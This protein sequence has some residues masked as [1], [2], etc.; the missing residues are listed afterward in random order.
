LLFVRAWYEMAVSTSLTVT[1]A[2]ATTLP[3]GS[4]TVPEILPATLAHIKAA[5]KM[6][7]TQMI[8]PILPAAQRN[9]PGMLYS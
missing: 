7:M 6:P 5:D 2:L 8:F 9:F 4:F 3:D 1:S